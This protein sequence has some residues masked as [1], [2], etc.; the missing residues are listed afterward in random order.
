M[1]ISMIAYLTRRQGVKFS[2]GCAGYDGAGA[3]NQRNL[4]LVVSVGVST[5]CVRLEF[6]GPHA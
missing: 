1:K 2:G 6:E 4:R 3:A 5:E